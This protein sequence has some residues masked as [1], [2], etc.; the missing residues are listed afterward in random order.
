MIEKIARLFFSLIQ[1]QKKIN[2]FLQKFSGISSK[3][4]RISVSNKHIKT[5]FYFKKANIL[6]YLCV[7]NY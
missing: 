2:Y 1:L 3:P 6:Y 4:L 7:K 5:N